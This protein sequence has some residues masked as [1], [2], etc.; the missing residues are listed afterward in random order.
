MP[1][2]PNLKAVIGVIVSGKQKIRLEISTVQV[3]LTAPLKL[4]PYG[5]IQICLLLLLLTA[6]NLTIDSSMLPFCTIGICSF[7]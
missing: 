3:Q 6:R 5:A 1:V 2:K 7:I 4:R